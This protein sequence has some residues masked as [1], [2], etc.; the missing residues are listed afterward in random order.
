MGL[1]GKKLKKYFFDFF[2]LKRT[3]T[4]F[5]KKL[6]NEAFSQKHFLDIKALNTIPNRLLVSKHI[7]GTAIL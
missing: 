3:K 2:A 6:E 5:W 7:T 4:H 1:F